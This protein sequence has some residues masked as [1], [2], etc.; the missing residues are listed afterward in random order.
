MTAL[1][2]TFS[3]V[4]RPVAGRQ[5]RPA[6]SSGKR[7]DAATYSRTRAS[8]GGISGRP[9]PQPASVANFANATGS[10]STSRRGLTSQSSWQPSG[11]QDR[12]MSAAPLTLA[13]RPAW[14]RASRAAPRPVPA[15]DLARPRP[16]A[17]TRADR[18]ARARAG[19]SDRVARPC[20]AP[21]PR[22]P[23][24]R[25]RPPSCPRSTAA[26]ASWTVQEVQ[27]PQFPR[28]TIATSTPLANSRELAPRALAL[29]ADAAARVPPAE[30]RAGG[31]EARRPLAR[32][33]EER[34]P[35]LVEADADRLAARAGRPAA[36]DPPSTSGGGAVGSRTRIRSMGPPGFGSKQYEE[37]GRR[38]NRR[39]PR[40]RR[41]LRNLRA[42]ARAPRPPPRAAAA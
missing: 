11:P 10:A 34:A 40:A 41:A 26:T 16:P 20:A 21:A 1:I 17:S 32:R 30:R 42:R 37:R 38:V 31:L 5:R 9:S 19:R 22:T 24:S 4:Q 25:R 6:R 28:P 27:E 12:S 15:R 14:L 2:A 23:A 3:T 8:V 18:E 36:R 29:V 33:D 7:P 35:D 13:L 39:G